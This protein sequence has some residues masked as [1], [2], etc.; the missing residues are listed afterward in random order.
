VT[1]KPGAGLTGNFASQPRENA[2]L[3][4]SCP[5]RI[6]VL[7]LRGCFASRSGRCSQD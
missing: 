1:L 5:M 7:R 3:N 6:W 2:F 4:S